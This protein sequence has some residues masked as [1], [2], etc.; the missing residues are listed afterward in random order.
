[1][2]FFFQSSTDAYKSGLFNETIKKII[3]NYDE[4]INV[5]LPTLGEEENLIVHFFNQSEITGKI[6]Q[7]PIGKLIMKIFCFI[8]EDS[9]LKSKSVLDGNCKLQWKVDWAMGGLLSVWTMKLP[10][11]I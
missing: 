5:V 6:L 2:P 3:K 11:R 1:M 8:Y 4:I 9:V 10:V 7:V